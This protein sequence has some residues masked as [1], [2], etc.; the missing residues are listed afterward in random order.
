MTLG[1]LEALLQTL[2]GDAA[3][4]ALVDG[5]IF[6]NLP[7]P[8][9]ER[10]FLTLQ[11]SLIS[12]EVGDWGGPAAFDKVLLVAD[13]R[14]RKSAEHCGEIARAVKSLLDDGID[15]TIEGTRYKVDVQEIRSKLIFSQELNAHRIRLEVPG[16]VAGSLAISSLSPSASSP[17]KSG[18]QIVFT[19]TLSSAEEDLEYRFLLQGPGTGYAWRD[20]TG[21][22]G[23]NSFPWRTSDQDIGTSTVKAQVRRGHNQAGPDAERTASFAISKNEGGSGSLPAI[24]SL[25]PSLS[26]PRGAGTR[27]DFICLA[28]DPDNDPLLYRFILNGPGTAGKAKIVQ[29]W[30]AKNAWS[31]T[32]GREE[33]GTNIIEVQVRD[34]NHAG[35]G[36]YDAHASVSFAVSSNTAPTARGIY[37]EEGPDLYIDQTVHL[38]A[39]ASDPDEDQ[40]FYKFL[41]YR[42]TVGIDW[43]AITG[44]QR[45]NWTTYKLDAL[46]Y[47]TLAVKVQ[48]R[49]G[50][51]AGEESCDDEKE[52]IFDI[53]RA[54]LT[55][56]TPSLPSPKAHETT[57]VFSAV[58]NKTSQTYYRFWL[59]GPGTGNVWRDMTGWQAKNSWSWRTADCDIGSNQVKCQAVDDPAMWNDSDT[60][61]REIIIGYTIA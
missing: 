37:I 20:M 27:I 54:A 18:S 35:P 19:C 47:E 57:I 51:H 28:S 12:C 26:S 43:E 16:I 45:E 48:V 44:W 49:D 50:K 3:I 55:S 53:S 10:Y 29:D 61:G 59:R 4:S 30:S 32:P 52:N 9:S 11:Q 56:V 23:R 46:D 13:I 33:I 8:A 39:T 40:I 36:S 21:W 60:A 6:K 24:N 22:Q 7:I 17:Q 42:E 25:T 2:K 15:R 58:G 31:W 1:H 38:I 14:S 34:G 5:R 41:I